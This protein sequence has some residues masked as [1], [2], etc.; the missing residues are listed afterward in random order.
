MYG[1]PSV[2]RAFLSYSHA[3]KT[4]AAWIHRS[5]ES[6]RL[7]K[8]IIGQETPLGKVAPRLGKIFRDRDELPAGE[9]LSEKINAALSASQ[10]LIVVC[11]PAA[12]K[13]EWVNREIVQF[14]KCRK[15]GTILAVIVDGTPYASNSR[16]EEC[17][18]PALKYVIDRDGNPT[19]ELAEP[20]AADIRPG[21][22]GRRFGILKLVAGLLALDLDQLVRRD[23]QRRQKRLFAFACGL[24]SISAALLILAV[25]A[26]RA[27][28]DALDQQVKAESLI[29]FM[30]GDLKERLQQ[31]GRLDALD[32]VGEKAL[33]YY[34]SLR[35][36]QLDINSLGRRA[37]AMHLLGAIKDARGDFAG[38]T[39]AFQEAEA[40]TRR[41]LSMEP[42]STRRVYEH[43]Q[44]S[45]WVGYSFFR[46]GQY[47][48]AAK[49]FLDYNKLT[50]QLVSADPANDKWGAEL[51]NSFTA[52]GSTSMKVGD[53]RL[54]R[55]Q[56]Q[57]ARRKFLEIIKTSPVYRNDM[58][59]ALAWEQDLLSLSGLPREA[60][61][62]SELELDLYG[63]DSA[64]PPNE[65]SAY[66]R[67]L[68]HRRIGEYL[69]QQGKLVDA[70]ASFS[71]AENIGKRLIQK[72]SSN[73][74]WSRNVA[75]T[76]VA[77]AE[78][79]YE[80]GQASEALDILDAERADIKKL[81]TRDAEYRSWKAEV[82][83]HTL[84]LSARIHLESKKLATAETDLEEL[85]AFLKDAITAAP[86]E[87]STI[88]LNGQFLLLLG[89]LK[90]MKGDTVAAKNVWTEVR[91]QQTQAAPIVG[92]LSDITAIGAMN[93]LGERPQAVEVARPYCAG[94]VRLRQIQDLCPSSAAR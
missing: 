58:A 17:F 4:V 65:V 14:K 73:V 45:Y 56:L 83:G 68:A 43:S 72:D 61:V 10:T 52:L 71:V 1:E 88:V 31:V 27:R 24:A 7:P 92:L 29:E 55:E 53:R 79:L 62:L 66:R 22:D 23:A 40:T 49:S 18:P 50:T 30:L 69:V 42:Q 94:G 33:T 34:Q 75:R 13:S 6:Y 38:A 15:N 89:D 19:P 84:L 76:S 12:A 74:T 37:Q 67:L 25:I 60:Q 90:A 5:L 77:R 87:P 81:T 20:L 11:S 3:D 44:S 59:Q 93:R 54:A 51:A 85:K 48:D 78:A 9:S 86:E 46:R 64:D 80:A 63:G 70:F 16:D 36:D 32:A 35:P 21:K 8:R 57:A 91:T 82:L 41:L 39:G 28:D 26:F 47:K 2:Y